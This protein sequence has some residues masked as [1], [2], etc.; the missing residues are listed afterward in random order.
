M[1]TGANKPPQGSEVYFE[2]KLRG[3]LMQVNAIDANTGTEVSVFGPAKARA[4][5]IHNATVKLA[6]VMKKNAKSE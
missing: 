1:A 6:Y 4:V 2:C 5:L 3:D